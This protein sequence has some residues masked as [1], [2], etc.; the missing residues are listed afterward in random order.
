MT[1]LCLRSSHGG[2]QLSEDG[3]AD[4]ALEAASY[5][6]VGAAFCS[7]SGDVVAGRWVVAHAGAD[8]DVEGAVELTVA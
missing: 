5:F 2:L 3:A 7:A 1:L 4:V 6:T 8:D